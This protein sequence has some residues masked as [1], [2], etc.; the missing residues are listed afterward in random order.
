MTRSLTALEAV[1]A[2]RWRIAVSLTIVMMAAYFGFILLVA[3]D[4]TLLGTRLAPGLSLGMLLGAGVIVVAWVLTWVYV[5]WA[6]SHYDR[7]LAELR[8]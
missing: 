5:R 6:N 8:K 2:A 1:S 4:K 3:F 7:A